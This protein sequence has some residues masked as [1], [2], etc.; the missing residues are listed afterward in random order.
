ME[1]TLRAKADLIEKIM[2]FGHHQCLAGAAKTDQEAQVHNT[3][4]QKALQKILGLVGEN[5][6][7]TFFLC[8][9]YLE[10]R[11]PASQRLLDACA[12]TSSEIEDQCRREN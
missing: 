12:V 4:A 8:R 11:R 10:G 9:N 1:N 2:L 6:V 3:K 7:N 5:K